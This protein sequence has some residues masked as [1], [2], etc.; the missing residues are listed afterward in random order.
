MASM[1]TTHHTESGSKL[2]YSGGKYNTR[3][4][5]PKLKAQ[6]KKNYENF[7]SKLNQDAAL[8][9]KSNSYS[10]KSKN[11]GSN[12][13]GGSNGFFASWTFDSSFNGNS[14]CGGFSGDSGGCSGGD[15]GGGC[16]GD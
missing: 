1:G 5:D 3:P 4:K 16:G 9:K 11:S 13:G 12:S 2:Y 6:S 10:M 8:K 7:T 15:S 14:D